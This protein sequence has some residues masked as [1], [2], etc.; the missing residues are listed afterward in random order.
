MRLKSAIAGLVAIAMVVAGAWLGDRWLRSSAEDRLVAELVDALPGLRG[1]EAQI[2]GSLVTPQLIA[3]SLDEVNLSA[4]EL[5]IDGFAISDLE[6]TIEGL[7]TRGDDPISAVTATGTAPPRTV[8]AAISRRTDIP[9][10]VELEL[11]DGELVAVTELVGVPVEAAA[12]FVLEPRAVNVE[13]SRIMLGG[14]EVSAAD[15][16]IDLSGILGVATI[17]LAELPPGLSLSDL[18]VDPGGIHLQL[19]GTNVRMN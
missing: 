2:G 7:P 4:T 5:I 14:V 17:D 12:T 8:L 6:V 15:I 18:S 9:E 16:P 3:G 11:R 10:G 1:T 13:F 19:T